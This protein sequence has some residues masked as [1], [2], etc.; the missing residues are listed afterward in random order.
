[1][2]PQKRMAL[3]GIKSINAKT[4]HVQPKAAFKY[5]ELISQLPQFQIDFITF[6]VVEALKYGF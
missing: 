6:K 4:A 2:I 1:M 3:T 5:N